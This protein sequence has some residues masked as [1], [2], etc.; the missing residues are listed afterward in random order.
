MPTVNGDFNRTIFG[1]GLLTLTPEARTLGA[2]IR[3][4]LE[5]SN[6]THG[7]ALI[8]LGGLLADTLASAPPGCRRS[9]TDCMLKVLT[10]GATRA[11][12]AIHRRQSR[13]PP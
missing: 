13:F 4:V 2:G 12:I 3:A 5:E 9:L 1:L 11:L 8:A 10:R 7:A 6:P